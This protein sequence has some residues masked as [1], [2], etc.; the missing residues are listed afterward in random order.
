MNA[1]FYLNFNFHKT[2]F[3][4]YECPQNNDRANIATGVVRYRLSFVQVHPCPRLKLIRVHRQVQYGP[5][6]SDSY[7]LKSWQRLAITEKT[8]MGTLGNRMSYT[9]KGKY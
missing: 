1:I 6:N 9:D 7:R 8:D 5:E 2:N 3:L 4:P